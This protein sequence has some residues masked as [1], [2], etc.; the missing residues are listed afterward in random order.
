MYCRVA[1]KNQIEEE[2]RNEERDDRKVCRRNIKQYI[3]KFFN[4]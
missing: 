3:K 2:K 1:N 4:I